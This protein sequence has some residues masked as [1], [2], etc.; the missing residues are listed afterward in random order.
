V[1][2]RTDI[3]RLRGRRVVMTDTTGMKY[4]IPDWRALDLRSQELLEQEM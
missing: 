2:E 1:R 3:R 4:E